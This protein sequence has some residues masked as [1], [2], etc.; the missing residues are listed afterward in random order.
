MNE[1]DFSEL[2]NSLHLSSGA[3]KSLLGGRGFLF[4]FLF[5]G[6]VA[7]GDR[8][9][10]GMFVGKEAKSFGGWETPATELLAIDKSVGASSLC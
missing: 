3:S 5:G 2:M 6:D 9:N 1:R 10:A 8:C 4:F 7:V